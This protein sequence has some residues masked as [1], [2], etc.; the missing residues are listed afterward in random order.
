MIQ[1]L[2]LHVAQGDAGLG[3]QQ[4]HGG[5]GQD[6]PLQPQR[7]AITQKRRQQHDLGWREPGT[8]SGQVI[9]QQSHCYGAAPARKGQAFKQQVF[10]VAPS[11]FSGP[12]SAGS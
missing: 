5:P 1:T 11:G 8:C 6:K 4:G 12:L 3:R 2:W 9:P 10:F 7:G